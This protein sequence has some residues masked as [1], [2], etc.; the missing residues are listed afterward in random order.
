MRRTLPVGAARPGHARALLSRHQA[1][2]WIF[3]QGFFRVGK[4]LDPHSIAQTERM[5]NTDIPRIWV[6]PV[7]EMRANGPFVREIGF[8]LRDNAIVNRASVETRF[9]YPD[10]QPLPSE[11][12]P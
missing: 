4:A 8:H 9:G 10:G 1:A 5:M 12:V 6:I 7:I 11:L 3:R 2:G